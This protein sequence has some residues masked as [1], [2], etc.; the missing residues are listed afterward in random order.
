MCVER[1]IHWQ[2]RTG[3]LIICDFLQFNFTIIWESLNTIRIYTL[4]KTPNLFLIL[5]S[6][7]LEIPA[8]SFFF[9]FLVF[10]VLLNEAR[11]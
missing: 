10:W 9:F 2:W 6:T 11:G 7:V 3:A 4:R 8:F 1:K 5:K